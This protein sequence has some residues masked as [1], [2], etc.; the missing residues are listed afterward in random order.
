MDISIVN[1]LVYVDDGEW[2]LKDFRARQVTLYSDVDKF[3]LFV[4]RSMFCFISFK[5]SL[6][7]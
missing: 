5:N 3:G 4:L 2:R 7:D 6:L 1:S